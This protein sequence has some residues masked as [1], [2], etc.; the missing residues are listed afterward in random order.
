MQLTRIDRWLRERF[1][2][3]THIFTLR[4]PPQLPAGII[5]RKVADAPGRTYR[6]KFIARN[7]RR[8]EQLINTLKSNNQMFATRIVDRSAWYVPLIAPKDKSLV[9]WFLWV[10]ISAA[11]AYTAVVA[12]RAVWSN[13]E[14]RQ[15]ILESLEILKG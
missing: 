3:E 13:D 10:L 9:Y 8:A 11:A 2:Y 4:K 14:L 6:H 1:V 15:N 7:P 5:A 12:A